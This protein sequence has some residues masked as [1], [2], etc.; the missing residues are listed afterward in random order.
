MNQNVGC[1]LVAG[2]PSS[3]KFSFISSNTIALRSPCHEH[4][5]HCAGCSTNIE[6]KDGPGP[7]KL[8]IQTIKQEKTDGYRETGEYKETM[9]Q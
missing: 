9:R 1:L 8:T 7:K 4:G 2:H 3:T 6:Q 5:P